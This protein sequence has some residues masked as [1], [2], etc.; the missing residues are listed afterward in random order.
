MAFAWDRGVFA[1]AYGEK[2]SANDELANDPIERS[3]GG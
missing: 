2:D 1:G 3:V